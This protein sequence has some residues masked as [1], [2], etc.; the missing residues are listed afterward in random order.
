MAV[1]NFGYK[2]TFQLIDKGNIELFGPT[3]VSSRLQFS[4]SQLIKLQSGAATNYAFVIVISILLF[5]L[6]IS[7]QILFS[8][9]LL[10]FDMLFLVVYSYIVFFFL[11]KV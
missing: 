6:S 4:S 9:S 7:L 10:F 8:K 2:K 5:V 1:M 3:G 11:F